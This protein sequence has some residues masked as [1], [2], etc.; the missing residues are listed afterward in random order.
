M[1]EYSKIWTEIEH[2]MPKIVVMMDDYV[3]VI[4]IVEI[5]TVM[6]KIHKVQVDMIQVNVFVTLDQKRH[7]KIE[8]KINERLR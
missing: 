8:L 4:Q 6:E 1:N 3:I 5:D 7:V 2:V